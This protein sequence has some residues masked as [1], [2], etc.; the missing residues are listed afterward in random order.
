MFKRIRK[1]QRPNRLTHHRAANRYNSNLRLGD[2]FSS[3]ISRVLWTRQ[4]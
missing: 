4:K 3:H 1:S 2:C